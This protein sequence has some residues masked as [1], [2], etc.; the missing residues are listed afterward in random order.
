MNNT[1]ILISGDKA[2]RLDS[3]MRVDEA[4]AQASIWW[5]GKGRDLMMSQKDNQRTFAKAAFAEPDPDNPNFL[6]SGVLNG[7]KWDHLNAREKLLVTKYWHHFFV[8]TQGLI[9]HNAGQFKFGTR[10]TIG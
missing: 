7:L 6:P 9:D 5:E 1:G 2:A 4:I 8:R 3:G 10:D